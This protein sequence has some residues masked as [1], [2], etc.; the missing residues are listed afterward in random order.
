MHTSLS[1]P[2]GL[3]TPL[4]LR[5]TTANDDDNDDAIT[6]TYTDAAYALTVAILPVCIEAQIQAGTVFLQ[7]RTVCFL[8]CERLVSAEKQIQNFEWMSGAKKRHSD[9]PVGTGLLP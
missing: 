9:Y 8:E 5:S 7:T 3:R 1:T 4:L 2:D 6:T